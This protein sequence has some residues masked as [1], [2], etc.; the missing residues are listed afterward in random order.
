MVLMAPTAL[1]MRRTPTSDR[2]YADA[3][4]R[5]PTLDEIEI[6]HFLDREYPRLVNAMALSLWKR[7]G[8]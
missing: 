6:R 1:P 3:S 4:A 2:P 8:G 5:R 7:A